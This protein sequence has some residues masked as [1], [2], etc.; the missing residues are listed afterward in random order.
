MS[1]TQG[2]E[3]L[4]GPE[5][6]RHL[7]ITQRMLYRYLRDRQIPSFKLG[8]EWRFVRSDLDEWAQHRTTTAGSR[9]TESPSHS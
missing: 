9:P 4:T 1:G 8:N 5:A 7:R 3:L 2:N 6:C